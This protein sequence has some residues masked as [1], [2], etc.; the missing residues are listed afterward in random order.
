MGATGATH[1]SSISKF[2]WTNNLD[3]TVSQAIADARTSINPNPLPAGFDASKA[4]YTYYVKHQ[5]NVFGGE[6]EWARG[7]FGDGTKWP[8]A[9]ESGYKGARTRQRRQGGATCIPIWPNRKS[10]M[11]SKA[12][13]KG[14]FRRDGQPATERTSDPF[15][16]PALYMK[17]IF[18]LT[19]PAAITVQ[20]PPAPCGDGGGQWQINYGI[21]LMSLGTRPATRE[22]P[23][24]AAL[25]CPM[26]E[27]S[28][29]WIPHG[30]APR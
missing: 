12:E 13:R 19:M 27:P 26:S 2:T 28:S 17:I 3:W 30:C 9:G 4:Y 10:P 8:G 23:R 14:T 6:D 25:S 1:L 24:T 11:I 18:G 21:C 5:W 22:S 15:M 7:E 29:A 20:N 16:Q